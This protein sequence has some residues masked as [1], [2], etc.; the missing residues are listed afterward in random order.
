V[1]VIFVREL[2]AN[3]NKRIPIQMGTTIAMRITTMEMDIM[4]RVPPTKEVNLIHENI[5]TRVHE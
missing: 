4:A 5:F 2:C 3:K 1:D